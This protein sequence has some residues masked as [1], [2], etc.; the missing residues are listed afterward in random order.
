LT[1]AVIGA[2]VIG[3]AV[4]RALLLKEPRLRIAVF[5]KEIEPAVHQ[6]GRNSG[7]IHVRYN[8]K[9]GSLKARF[10]VEGSHRLR[11]FCV[12]HEI[13]MVQNGILVVAQ[14]ESE[15]ATLG[16]GRANGAKVEIV[17]EAEIR[18]REPA[19]AGATALF[20]AGELR[21]QDIRFEAC[22]Q[23]NGAGAKLSFREQVSELRE[24][25]TQVEVTIRAPTGLYSP[26]PRGSGHRPFSLVLE[27][28]LFGERAAGPSR[29]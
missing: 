24:S 25:S 26:A 1:V 23:A 27:E 21:F 4:A 28:S 6:S 10:V 12:Q 18:K 22:S 13:G 19:A 11:E 15:D 16:R 20:A 8:E 17:D 5:E 14:N 2:G 9:P 29:R 3:C 7:V